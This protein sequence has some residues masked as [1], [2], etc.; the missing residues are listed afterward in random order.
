MLGRHGRSGSRLRERAGEQQRCKQGGSKDEALHRFLCECIGGPA[1]AD[2][3][4]VEIDSSSVGKNFGETSRHEQSYY[5]PR[6]KNVNG[7][8][9][10]QGNREFRYETYLQQEEPVAD[11]I[12]RIRLRKSAPISKSHLPAARRVAKR[13][14]RFAPK[15]RSC[16]AFRL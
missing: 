7:S 8:G 4:A 12:S 9:I 13:G 2:F 3:P 16:A 1:R 10:K 15:M 6:R 11:R 5:A 14:G